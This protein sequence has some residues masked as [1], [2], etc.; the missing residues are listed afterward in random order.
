MS[1]AIGQNGGASEEIRRGKDGARPDHRG[2][3]AQ[4]PRTIACHPPLPPAPPVPVAPTGQTA[5]RKVLRLPL[6][7]R[8][9]CCRM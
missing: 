3:A 4:A 5:G 9:S 8:W 7:E 1:G 6:S 2:G